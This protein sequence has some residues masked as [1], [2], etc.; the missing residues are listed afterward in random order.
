[1]VG[2]PNIRDISMPPEMAEVLVRGADTS[3]I[4]QNNL[5]I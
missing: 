5:D 3:F 1:M 4:G 2:S